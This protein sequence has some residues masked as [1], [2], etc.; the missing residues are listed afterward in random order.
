MQTLLKSRLTSVR[1]NAL[2]KSG[3]KATRKVS[4]APSG[5]YQADETWLPNASRPGAFRSCARG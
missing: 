2:F 4:K 3:T 1:C 5:R